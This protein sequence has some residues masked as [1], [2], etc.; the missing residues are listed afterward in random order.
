MPWYRRKW[1]P[2]D[3]FPRIVFRLRFTILQEKVLLLGQLR[4]V[5]EF[6]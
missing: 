4:A 3:D 1:L 6:I 5:E 2:T